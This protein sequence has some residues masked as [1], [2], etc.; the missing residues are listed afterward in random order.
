MVLACGTL[1]AVF[2]AGPVSAQDRRGLI[3]GDAGAASLG[4]ADSEQGKG[5]IL[6][7]GAAFRLTPHLLVEGEVHGGRVDHVF[8][9]DQHTFSQVTLTGSVLLQTHP[10]QS[11]HFVIGGGL[12]L[13]RAHTEFREP[14]LR[15]VDRVE[16]IRLLHGRVG[17]DWDLSNRWVLRTHAVL[18]LGA[19][20]DWI[21]GGR[22]G[23]GYR[24]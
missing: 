11:A 4:H 13:Q 9:R 15:P 5:A 14:P 23:L 1:V 8:G 24:F 7:G 2:C 3:F 18:W 17:A 6:G 10:R 22:L 16:T 21:A 19:G 12:A 20:L